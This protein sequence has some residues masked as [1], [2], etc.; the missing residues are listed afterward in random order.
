MAFIDSVHQVSGEECNIGLADIA[1][2]YRY[3]FHN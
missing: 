3:E 1:P 2:R